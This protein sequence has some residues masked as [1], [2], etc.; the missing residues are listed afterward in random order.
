M[1]RR[2]VA[3]WALAIVFLAA[4]GDKNV[5]MSRPDIERFGLAESA[6]DHPLLASAID[7]VRTT[8]GKDAKVVLDSSW[9][10][11]VVKG[12]VPVYAVSGNGLGAR[13]IMSTY[14]ECG[15]VLVQASALS[16]WLKEHVGSSDALLSV[17]PQSLLAYM[18]L[19]EAGHISN[20]EVEPDLPSAGT[21]SSRSP[22]NRDPTVQKERERRADAFAA[23]AIKAALKYEGT[24]RGLAAAT[25]AMALSQLSWNLS[26]H[27]ALDNF[28]GTVLHKPSLF[29]D[30]GASHPNLEWRIL[31]VNALISGTEVSR[32]LLEEFDGA[33]RAT[34]QP[35]YRSLPN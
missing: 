12:A 35:L 8:Q 11:N 5:D 14:I 27:R 33:R 23:D 7:T 1:T 10:P 20:N 31:T 2:T 22:F 24:D 30:G 28:G 3:L 26:V 15:C 6:I 4:C 32:Q 18:L 34:P 16:N 13:E 21:S 17:D 25:I 9:K 19:H 29:W